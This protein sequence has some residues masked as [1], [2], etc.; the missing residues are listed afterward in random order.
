MTLRPSNILRLLLTMLFIG[1]VGSIARAQIDAS[2]LMRAQRQGQDI[3]GGYGA[4]TAD[5]TQTDA[6]GNPAEGEKGDTT[7]KK[8]PRKPLESYFFSDSIR[9]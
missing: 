5:G 7:K 9:A 4:P 3:T 6:N 2:A 8:R 1:M